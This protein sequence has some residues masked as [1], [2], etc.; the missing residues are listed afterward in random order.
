[1]DGVAPPGRAR[2]VLLAAV[3]LLAGV[4]GVYLAFFRGG[5]E[6]RPVKAP[7]DPRLDYAGPFCN[8]RPD[9]H[10]VPDSRCAECHAE[11]CRT[12]AAHPMGR[13][14]LP[15]AQAPSPPTGPQQNNPFE[16]RGS[17]YRVVHEGGKTY[18]RRTKTGPDGRPVAELDWPVDYV[19]GS[20]AR[21]YSYL[22]DRDGFLFETPVSWYSQKKAWDLS[23]GFGDAYLTGRPA[24]PDCLFCHTNRADHRDG[25]V[26]GYGRPPFDGTAIGCQRCHGPGELHVASPGKGPDG[27]DPT[28]VNPRHLDRPLREA[29]CEQCHLTGEQRVLRR[30]RDLYDYRPGLP[31]ELFWSVFVR[32]PGE[33]EGRKAVGHVEQTD[34]SR[35]FRGDPSFGC[36]SCHDP[37]AKP[38]PERRV[39]YYRDR[40]L[41]CHRQKGCSLPEAERLRR[42]PA[43]SCIDCHMP[44]YG[45]SDIPH[46]ASTD[47]R[48]LR[49]PAA[50]PAD[51][52][53]AGD[54][55]PLVSFYRGRP[56]PEGGADDRDRAIALVRAALGGDAA[57]R[58]LRQ[59][60]PALDAAAGRDPDDL[61]AAEA[62]GQALGLQG[63]WAEALAAFRAV[64]ERS[65][66][67]ELS[68][69]G[70]ATMAEALGQTDDAVGYWRRAAAVNPWPPE[71]RR[72]LALLLVKKE[73][74]AEALPECTAWV[75]LDPFSAEARATRVACLLATGDKAEAR[76][77]FQRVEALAPP[78][79]PELRIRFE[80]RLK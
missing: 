75:R 17:Q 32:A 15:T 3:G 10:Y 59:V 27:V 5:V 14:T 36:A 18:H 71:Y 30:G 55:L 29:V 47:H 11:V 52:K 53:P 48:V 58:S 2:V 79:L 8:V 37:H 20:G 45:S 74:W 9:V 64:L 44:R 28:I 4:A 7:R 63:R 33:K 38:P 26:N 65:P 67:R 19:V 51:A 69:G 76:A 40:C 70:A 61:P 39:A 77:E 42:S 22:T 24:V 21:G 72:S 31:P 62:R 6:P 12:F 50:A 80:R 46:T 43:D 25:T 49:E 73:A 23:P 56:A 68:L 66:D 16:A 78:N 35:C 34:Q 54:G 1:M 13:S 60:L 57:A 41:Q